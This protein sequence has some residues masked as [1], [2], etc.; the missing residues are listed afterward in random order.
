LTEQFLC[1][2]R[3]VFPGRAFLSVPVPPAMAF[4]VPVFYSR[5]AGEKVAV[6]D[7]FRKKV[8]FCISC[9]ADSETDFE[10]RSAWR[11]SS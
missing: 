6:P 4:G 8:C 2:F 1:P 10:S 11:F 9:I 7:G 3:L 5:L